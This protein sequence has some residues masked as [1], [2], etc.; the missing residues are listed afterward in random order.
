MMLNLNAFGEMRVELKA[1][2]DNLRLDTR[3]AQTRNCRIHTKGH[4]GNPASHCPGL[5]QQVM[6]RDVG[7]RNP[8]RTGLW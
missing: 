1:A 8:Q 5:Q 3:M 2:N 4:A 7:G 6:R